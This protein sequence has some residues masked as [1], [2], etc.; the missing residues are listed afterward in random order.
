MPDIKHFDPDAALETIVRLFWR[1]GV[2]STGVQDIVD[3]TGVSRSSLYATFGDKQALYV[4]ALRSYLQKRSV[5]NFDRLA[6]DGRGLPAVRE[7]FVR[8]IAVRSTG[9]FARWGCL[10]S[11]AQAAGD[12][13]DVHVREILD[14]HHERL[15]R[16]LLAALTDADRLGQLSGALT[17]ADAAGVLALMAY[18]INVRSRAGADP[19]ELDAMVDGVLLMLGGPRPAALLDAAGSA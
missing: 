6:A 9:E 5:P 1:D 12:I 18:G 3:A 11:N 19:Q 17:P 7:F 10:A 14:S 16:A 13:E 2:V 15:Q 4:T 8:L